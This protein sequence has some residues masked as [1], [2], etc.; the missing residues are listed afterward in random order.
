MG[1][2][3]VKRILEIIP[4][5]FIITFIVFFLVR[6]SGDPVNT[7]LPP[8]ATP[9]D[10]QELREALG[11]NKP[12]LEQYGIFL[13]DLVHG[14]FG[15]SLR[16]GQEATEVVM[17][18]LPATLQLATLSL[19]VS[20]V[21]GVVLGVLCARTKDT[22]LDVF[23]NGLAVVGQAMPSFW[24]GIML[25][26]LFGVILQ[27]LPVSGPGDWKNL[28]LP[29]STLSIVTA[30]QIIPLVRSSMLEIMHEDYI[31]TARSKGLKGGLL[32]ISTPSKRTDSCGDDSGA[33]GPQS[34]RWIPDYGDCV[35]LA[36]TGAASD[37]VYQRQG[38]VRYC[39]RVWFHLTDHD[40]SQFGGRYSVCTDRPAYPLLTGG[41][42]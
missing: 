41:A 15:I 5:L 37:P 14:R 30:A 6:V 13:S 31:R 2:Y 33:S 16:Y 4:V 1:R 8:E 38:Y 20:T 23:V 21:L 18:K 7:M 19:L 11:L 10:R 29:V 39:R 25:I 35:C 27:W 22:V 28:V 36:G 17:E 26:L 40:R 24:I 32:Y 3:I 34:D 12:Y 42:T 9:E